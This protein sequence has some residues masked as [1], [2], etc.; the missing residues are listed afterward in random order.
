MLGLDP[1]PPVRQTKHSLFP[2]SSFLF[3]FFCQYAVSVSACYL[4]RSTG[5]DQ[6]L[7]FALLTGIYSF[8]LHFSCLFLCVAPLSEYL[9]SRDG[10]E[11]PSP[12]SGIPVAILVEILSLCLSRLLLPVGDQPFP[13][14]GHESGL[15][16]VDANLTAV[17]TNSALYSDRAHNRF[18]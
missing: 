9:R 4:H 11:D 8:Q 15:L 1:W 2:F 3:F 18:R 12:G 13:C 7:C 14:L 10:A 6:C 5:G 16:D 17:P